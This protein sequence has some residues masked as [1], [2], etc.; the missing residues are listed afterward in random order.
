MSASAEV[1]ISA[2]DIPS[3]EDSDRVIDAI[4][5]RLDYLGFS[6]KGSGFTIGRYLSGLIIEAKD[7]SVSY[8]VFDENWASGLIR[9]VYAINGM[10]SL[11][12]SVYNL[13]R[14]ADVMLTTW[15]V[16]SENA[17]QVAND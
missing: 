14:T 9:D 13:D 2:S 4:E 3:S 6:T 11:E 16:F 1:Y 12:I 15:D 7:Y 10:I 5:K 8:D 17:Q